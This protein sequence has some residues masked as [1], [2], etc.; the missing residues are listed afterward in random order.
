M[1]LRILDFSARY[2]W[3][4]LA[5]VLLAAGVGALAMHSVQLDAIPDLSEP[6]VIVYAEWMGRSPTL[7]EEQVTY[8]IVSSLLGAPK[9]RDVRGLTMFGMTF[10]YVI[11][12]EGTDN[13]WAR[14]RVLETLS[15]ISNRLP[16]GVAPIL[17]PD[18]SGVGWAFQ[19][20]LVDKQGHHDL[21][22]LRALQD[23]HLRYAL[24]AV[25]GVAE[26]A[27]VGGFSQEYQVQID[28]QRLQIW[29]LTLPE[30]TAAIRQSSGDSGGRI[31]ELSGREYYVRGLGYVQSKSDL[32]QLVLRSVGPSGTPIRLSDVA[33]VRLGPAQRRGVL[34][35]NGDGET[36]G[37]IVVV[38]QGENALAVIERV[39][40]KIKEL[41]RS[42][43]DGVQ[44][45]V[46]YDRSDL[47]HRAIATLR[48]ALTEEAITVSAVIILFLLHFRSSLL[49]ILSLPVAVLLAFIPMYLLDIPS[50][51]MSLGGLAIALGASVDAEIV[52]IE[53]AHKKLEQAHQAKD[54]PRL[55]REAAQEVTP[56]IF[57]SLL[58]IAVAFLPVFTLTGQAGRLFRPMAWTKTFVMLTSALL[59]VTFAPALRDLML[60][61]PIRAE[62]KHP[63]SR[64]VIALYKPFVFVALRNPRTTI[65]MGL[66]AVLSAVPL[67]GQ[68]GHE[69]MPAL[70]EGDALYMP[71]TLPNISIETAAAQLQA[72][73]RLLRQAPEVLSV[74]GKVGRADTATDPAPLTMVETTVRLRPRDQWR[75]VHVTRWWSSWAPH[76]LQGPL[77]SVAPDEQPI[78]WDALMN[79]L[80]ARLQMPG[81]TNAWTMPIKTRIDMLATGIRTPIGVKVQGQT[82]EQ[83][84]RVGEQLERLLAQLPGTRSALYE[85][86]LGGLYVDIKPKREA[87]ARFGLTNADIQQW[88]ETAIGGGT[89][90]STL[91]GRQRLGVSLR[92]PIDARADLEA[93]RRLPINGQIQQ[94]NQGIRPPSATGSPADGMGMSQ[95]AAASQ[96]GPRP[97]T[98]GYVGPPLL[99]LGEVT[100]IQISKGPPML[101]DEGGMLT[102]YVY[103]DVD[104]ARIDLGQYVDHAKLAVDAAIAGKTL[105]MPAGTLLHWTGQY[106]QMAE[107][108]ARMKWV[109]PLTLLLVALLLGLHFGNLASVLIVL[110]SVPFALTGSVWLL[111]AMDYRLST[112]VWVGIIALVGLAAQT[113]V[114]MIVYIDAAYHRREK[115]GLINNLNDIIWAHL[116]GTVQRVRPK[117]MTVA[118]MLMGLLPLLWSTGSGADV[119]KRVAV[120]MI[121][122]LLTSAFLTLEI[123]P[124]VYTYWRAEQLLWRRL[125]TVDL[126][127]LGILKQLRLVQLCGWTL[128]ALL[129]VLPWYAPPGPWR[130]MALV[131][132]GVAVAA[133]LAYGWVRRPV[134][135]WIHG[136]HGA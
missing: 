7:V 4:V 29:G 56:A 5:A 87:M 133:G 12:E 51:I 91:V 67:I 130:T 63:I 107:M 83:V 32:S 100:D 112:A 6:Q 97:A 95:P 126:R 121:G 115:A 85:R 46:A 45:E 118:T 39:K 2:R 36:V 14:G 116:E 22:Q 21:G 59:S 49:P 110:L 98:Q 73:D 106:E 114:V 47:I 19:Y 108:Q 8:P 24:G 120:P 54:R 61:G 86:S 25:R 20:V 75:K 79:E 53:A 82:V 37:G 10:V 122:G 28:P 101:R 18:A 88:V 127:R 117:L 23:T 96:P 124:V 90:S 34:D 15:S 129:A 71:I 77:R 48:Q 68:L 50:T 13:Y 89:L 72:Q 31:L 84:E 38:R 128:A 64:L 76:W 33:Q 74:F 43:P 62:A 119:M 66:L 40:A 3:L 44:I 92:L 26:V 105:Q 113:G 123:I 131:C 136:V 11:F 132:A 57:Y 81:W 55:L 111:W 52:M 135:H 42:L 125:L 99:T 41:Q 70:E 109:L 16:N 102:G 134:A 80:D 93:L 69:F 60:R 9:V 1:I 58:I 65:L 17:G 78:G 104:E 103:V 35:W 30:V 27:S 94:T